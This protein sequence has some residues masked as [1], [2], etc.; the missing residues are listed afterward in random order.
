MMNNNDCGNDDCD[1][2][3]GLLL[4]TYHPLFRIRDGVIDCGVTV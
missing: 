3:S 4:P 2:G 1:D